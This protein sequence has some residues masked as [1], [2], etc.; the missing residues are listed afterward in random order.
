MVLTGN[1]PNGD[2][3]ESVEIACCGLV[4]ELGAAVQVGNAPA[5]STPGAGPF[6]VALFAPVDAEVITVVDGGLGT[7]DA[8]FG[9]ISLIVELHGVAVDT[10]LDA[11]S[12]GPAFEVTDHFSGEVLA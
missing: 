6:A 7:Q 11:Y 1:S 10:V 8:A 12:L 2:S 5:Q 4:G 9:G 3:G